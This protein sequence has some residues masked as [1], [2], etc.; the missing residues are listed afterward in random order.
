MSLETETTTNEAPPAEA[1]LLIT[2]RAARQIAPP[3]P[4]GCWQAS[5]VPLH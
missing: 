3:L 4:A 5:A 1:K 2:D